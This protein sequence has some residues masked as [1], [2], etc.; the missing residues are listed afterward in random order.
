MLRSTQ[1]LRLTYTGLPVAILT[2]WLSLTIKASATDL[3]L[4]GDFEEGFTQSAWNLSGNVVIE[5]DIGYRRNAHAVGRFPS[6]S[7]IAAFNGADRAID[8]KISQI[9]V[10]APGQE[11]TLSFFYGNY[12]VP[13]VS[14]TQVI[15]ANVVDNSNS[16][17]IA[18]RIIEQVLGTNDLSRVLKPYELTFTATSNQTQIEFIDA[19][20]DT[21]SIDGLVDNIQL[22]PTSSTAVPFEFSPGL[23]LWLL[24]GCHVIKTLWKKS[25]NK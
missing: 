23:G 13:G 1:T 22:S 17:V 21:F 25:K 15:K 5:N 16:V 24:A 12:T 11:Y 14:G 6:G 8:G 2:I 18:N 3:I 9:V 4:N 19:S 20:F 7:Y 10:T